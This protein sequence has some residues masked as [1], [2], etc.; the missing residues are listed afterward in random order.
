MILM[1][2]MLELVMGVKDM[3]VDKV[4][5]DVAD[6]IVEMEVDK[7]A[8]M[9]VNIPNEDFTGVSLAIAETDIKEVK[10]E[11]VMTCDVPPVAKFF[12]QKKNAMKIITHLTCQQSYP[13]FNIDSALLLPAMRRLNAEYCGI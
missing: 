2:M 4:A 13:T 10:R 8:E 9:V 12:S 6:I 7:V 1:E 5:D 11:E 3:E